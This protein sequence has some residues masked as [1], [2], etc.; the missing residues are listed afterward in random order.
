[1]TLLTAK[2]PMGLLPSPIMELPKMTTM[3]LVMSQVKQEVEMMMLMRLLAVI[4]L[5]LMQ[6]TGR[7]LG[8]SMMQELAIRLA[9]MGLPLELLLLT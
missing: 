4:Q 9:M 3:G 5:A 6:A 7:L 8:L 2:W 1:M